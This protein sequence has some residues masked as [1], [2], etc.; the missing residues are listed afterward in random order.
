[1]LAAAWT[2]AVVASLG[3]SLG[4]VWGAT[5]ESVRTVARAGHE[6]DV[7]YRQW[8]SDLGGVYARVEGGVEPNPYLRIQDR[9]L[10]T[11]DGTKLTLINP[12]SM[13]RMVH[14]IA[15]EREGII[16]HITSLEPISPQN[17][18]DEWETEALRRLQSGEEE[19]SGISAID[20]TSHM[21]LIRPLVTK[22]DCLQCHAA[23]GYKVGDI[24]GGISVSVPM[25]PFYARFRRSAFGIAGGHGLVWLLGIAGLATYRRRLGLATEERDRALA[26][27]ERARDDLENEVRRRT[28]ELLDSYG[29]LQEAM[30]V[31]ERFLANMSH[32]MRTPMNSIIGFTGILLDGSPGPLT[33]E[34]RS[35]LEMISRAGGNLI[36]LIEDTLDFGEVEAGSLELDSETFD[37]CDVVMRIAEKNSSAARA[38]GLELITDCYP[39]AIELTS[40]KRRF[41]QVVGNLIDNAVKFTES[42]SVSVGLEVEGEVLSVWVAD[43][44]PGLGADETERVFEPFWQHSRADGGNVR[45][46]GLGLAL[47]HRLAEL[48]GGS[49]EV[50]SRPEHGSTFTFRIPIEG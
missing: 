49:L 45:G 3:L 37:A 50:E 44:G 39:R 1:M 12:A 25:E 19:V 17:A 11:V 43:T 32:E 2:L 48:L 29:R 23:Q 38:K 42:G 4:L 6:I 13:T 33:D 15:L 24:R 18:A 47:T 22:E 40:D 7:Q 46:I 30:D 21:R 16:R 5:L 34:Q 10:E 41:S 35:Q 9:D 14:D 8:N 36:R 28:A 26:V 27:A 20:G 31:R